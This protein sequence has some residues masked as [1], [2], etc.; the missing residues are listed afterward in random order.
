MRK[1]ILTLPD[2]LSLSLDSAEVWLHRVEWVMWAVG[3][4]C[5]VI[6]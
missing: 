4:G 3:V 6:L 1:S 2:R 5:W